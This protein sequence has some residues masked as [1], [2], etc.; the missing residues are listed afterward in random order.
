MDELA[1]LSYQAYR[2]LIYETPELLIY[3]EQA[4]PI[5]EIS[6][7]QIGSRPSKRGGTLSLDSLRAI[8][9]GFSWMQSRHVLPGWYGV[10]QA[11]E[12]FAASPERL[13]LLQEMYIEWP[14]FRGVLE[15]A[16]ISLAKADLGIAQ[17][18]SELVEDERVRAQIWGEIEGAF[19]QTRQMI[20]RVTGRRRFWTMPR[21][22]KR[23]CGSGTRMWT[24]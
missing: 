24:R 17:I 9:W 11:L 1:Q 12:A 20:L 18:Y 8:P 5:H 19:Q 10:G 15:N 22:C 4:T 21:R 14:F 23:R 2:Q 16:Q 7:M 13:A 6:Q 3:W